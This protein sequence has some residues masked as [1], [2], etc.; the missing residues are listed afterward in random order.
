MLLGFA[1][2]LRQPLKFGLAVHVRLAFFGA[3][4]FGGN[5]ALLYAA[6]RN[7]TSGLVAIIFSTSVLMNIAFGAIFLRRKIEIHIVAAAVL[8]LFGL[9]L[10][11]HQELMLL[12][13]G[14]AR[15]LA[16]IQALGATMLFSLGNIVSAR[17]QGERIPALVSTAFA[18][19]Y[20]ALMLIL[21][22]VVAGKPFVVEVSQSY[23]LS[24]IYLT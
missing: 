17:L 22:A 6:I 1:A 2:S 23:L 11:F 9:G 21:Y 14:N 13:F 8:G 5:F 16:I 19:G 24:L 10:V 4:V 7:L 3:L 15:T 20:G 18:M 12:D